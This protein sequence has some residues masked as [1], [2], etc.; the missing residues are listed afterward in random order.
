MKPPWEPQPELQL[1]LDEPPQ[2]PLPQPP[3]LQPPVPQPVPQLEPV[4]VQPAS[5]PRAR[6]AIVTMIRRIEIPFLEV[7]VNPYHANCRGK[8]AVPGKIAR[9]VRIVN[10]IVPGRSRA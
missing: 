1:E 10:Y 2:P 5:E 3:V 4:V 7:Q 6:N 9:S 8:V